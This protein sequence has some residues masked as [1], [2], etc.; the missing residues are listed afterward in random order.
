MKAI[1]RHRE[2]WQDKSDEWIFE[3]LDSELKQK[4]EEIHR[5][6]TEN[7]ALRK[8]AVS[9]RLYA[10]LYNSCVHESSWAT[11]SLHYSKEGAEKAMQDHKQKELDKFNEM[12]ANDNTVDFK[13]GEH[14]NWSVEPVE[15]LP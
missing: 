5:L 1:E 6:L 9:G 3:R 8:G 12:F 11:I 10:F 7:E 14:E 13:F 4:V 15:V 2:A